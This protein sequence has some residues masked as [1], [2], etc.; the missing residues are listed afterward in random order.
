M[1]YAIVSLRLGEPVLSSAKL[2]RSSDWAANSDL[3]H[4]TLRCGQHLLSPHG[5]LTL[6]RNPVGLWTN[7]KYGW[8]LNDDCC[9]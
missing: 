7:M 3:T 5:N 6:A 4:V 8:P 2:T 9:T 1:V